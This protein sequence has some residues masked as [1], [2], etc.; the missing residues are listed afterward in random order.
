MS[1]LSSLN[2]QCKEQTWPPHY[3]CQ[4]HNES[5]T[6]CEVIAVLLTKLNFGVSFD[7]SYY[8]QWGVGFVFYT[9][10]KI[11]FHVSFTKS[12]YW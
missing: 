2:F 8:I 10:S 7:L 1:Y 3:Q 6:I 9:R 12:K 11:L 5:V 4:M